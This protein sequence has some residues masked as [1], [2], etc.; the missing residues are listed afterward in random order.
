MSFITNCSIQTRDMCMLLSSSRLFDVQT[1]Y[2]L[3]VVVIYNLNAHLIMQ[4]PFDP[5][6]GELINIVMANSAKEL[7]IH[8]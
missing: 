8:L 4:L 1:W 2:V 7:I 3:F 5:E 6:G